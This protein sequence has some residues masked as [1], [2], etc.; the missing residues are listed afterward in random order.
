M[1]S[2]GIK[3]SRLHVMKTFR[4][5][6]PYETSVFQSFITA[7]Q[8]FFFNAP[9]IFPCGYESAV[10]R[11]REG[12]NGRKHRHRFGHAAACQGPCNTYILFHELRS[13]VRDLIPE[14]IL[15][16]NI[17]HTWVQFAAVPEF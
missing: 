9:R 5:S 7:K 14:L 10:R 4:L 1:E 11:W 16:Q 17:I 12:T 3:V 8:F 13:L 15:S 2:A 6:P